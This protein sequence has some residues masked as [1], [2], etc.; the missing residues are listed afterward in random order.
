[1]THHFYYFPTL[2]AKLN[3]SENLKKLF[4]IPKSSST[5]YSLDLI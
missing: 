1:M 5:C 4:N 3:I 2:S